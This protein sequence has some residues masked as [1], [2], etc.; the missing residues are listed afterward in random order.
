MT[1]CLSLF[2]GISMLLPQ[3]AHTQQ[4]INQI[5]DIA[6]HPRLL[7]TAADEAR[8]QAT[9]EDDEVLAEL[10]EIV[11]IYADAALNE[12]VFEYRF[13]DGATSY[14]GGNPRLKDQRREA[15]FRVFNLALT[16]R[17]TG[18]EQYA[19]RAKADL[20]AGAS[21]PD[22]HSNHFLNIG[23]ITTL[24]AVGYDWLYSYLTESERETIREAIVEFGLKEGLKVYQDNHP[25]AWWQYRTNNWNQVCNAGLIM[26][27]IAVADYY[28]ALASEIIDEAVASIPTAM[29]GYLPDGA[30]FEGPTYWA[31][32]T[33][34]NAMLI[35]TLQ[36]AFG[37]IMNL[38]KKE[39]YNELGISGEFHKMVIGPTSRYFNF[40]D[41]KL[42]Y[43]YSPVMYWLAREFDRPDYAF[44]ERW[45]NEL[46][47]PRM[48]DMELMNDDTLDRF[49]ALL[50]IW[51]DERGKDLS[52]E[53]FA[54]N[55]QFG[56]D[57]MVGI[58]RSDWDSPDA[59]YLGFKGGYNQSAHGRLDI[60]M[61]VLDAQN[62]RWALNLQSESS[63]Q[64]GYFDFENRRWDYFRANNHG[65]NTL[66]FD[67]ELQNIYARGAIETFETGEDLSY[68]VVD[69]SEAYNMNAESVQ[70]GFAM[71]DRRR[72][73]IQDRIQYPMNDTN[74]RWAM[75][76]AAEIEIE[77]SRAVLTQ[78]GEQLVAEILEPQGAFFEIMS[79]EPPDDPPNQRPAGNTKMMAVNVELKA[80]QELAD[81]TVLLTPVRGDEDD[82]DTPSFRPVTSVISS[83]VAS[84]ELPNSFELQGNYPNPFNPST[85]IVFDLPKA[86]DVRVEVYDLMGRRVLETQRY[87][88][89]AGLGLSI[90][91][92]M[93]EFSSGIYIYR[94]VGHTSRETITRSGKMTL[95]K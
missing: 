61:F 62:V 87:G 75:I 39:G 10:I 21:F 28:P 63:T 11:R 85:R 64:P 60:G 5:N 12:P 32:G 1:L 8:I 72:V 68:A 84:G 7:F 51:Y 36:S 59:I 79:T 93:S 50:V 3:I 33:T 25:E 15:M 40:G 57:S 20:L 16:Y 90:S 70:R 29:Q 55:Q 54:L 83:A 41:A 67:D 27:A 35:A 14:E 82:L 48:R 81:L 23:E 24:M 69:M 94:L 53:D 19:E 9:A 26:G 65:H 52:V 89:Q 6:D 38:D 42:T 44:F 13:D 80:G 46:D 73:M 95:I 22:W 4:S 74:V 18:D 86:T 34:Y 77:D 71:I 66:A 49:L 91:L 92:D 76:N 37:N 58:M 2:I 31:Y 17:L 30:W 88:M 45:M 47:F 56:G 78:D 43:Y